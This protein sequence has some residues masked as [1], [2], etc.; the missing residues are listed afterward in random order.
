FP[1]HLAAAAAIDAPHLQ[2]EQY[3]HVPAGQVAHLPEFAVVPSHLD[4]ATAATRCFFD[5]RFKV[6]MRTVGSPKTPRT[7]GSTRNPSNEYVSQSRR[8][9]FDILAIRHLCQIS[10]LAK[11]QNIPALPRF[12]A[13]QALEFTHSIPRRPLK[14]SIAIFAGVPK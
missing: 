14:K 9:R 11:I 10:N 1:F 2:L 5:R 3:S 6:T 4:A 13:L 8:R 7:T 12:M